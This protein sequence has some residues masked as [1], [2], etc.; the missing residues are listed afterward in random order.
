MRA[1][2]CACS[3]CGRPTGRVVANFHQNGEQ[4]DE[5]IQIEAEEDVQPLRPAHSPETPTAK[6]MEE[7]RYNHIPYRDWCKWCLMGR[8]RGM[9]HRHADSSWIAVV[10][11]DYFYITAGGVKL[12]KELDQT[13][14]DAGNAALEEERKA[15]NIVKCIMVRCTKS[16]NLFAHVVPY[17]GAG[18][19]RFVAELVTRDV[20]WLGHTRLIIKADNEPALRTLVMQ[21]LEE[22]RLK[23]VDIDNISTENPPKYDSQSNGG[24]EVG[25]QLV[26]GIFR[27]LKLCLE[28]RI[29]KFIPIN[30]AVIPWLLEHTC[31]ILNVRPMG[32]DGQTSWSRVRGRA[33]NQRLLG[34]GEVVFYKLPVKGPAHDPDGNMGTRWVE[35]VFLGYHRSSNT[36]IVGNA[37]GI[38]MAR[39]IARRPMPE[40]WSADALV[41]VQATPWSMH[42]SQVRVRFQDP[43]APAEGPPRQEPTPA[44][45]RMRINKTDLETH[46]YTDGC[47]QCTHTRRYGGA[48]PG[49]THTAA[50][51]ARLVEAIGQSAAGQA[52]LGDYEERLTRSMAEHIERQDVTAA[53]APSAPA[54]APAPPAARRGVL[55]GAPASADADNGPRRAPGPEDIRDGPTGCDGPAAPHPTDAGIGPPGDVDMEETGTEA[56]GGD[57]HMGFI[58][59][60]EPARDDFVSELLLSQ[61]GSMGRRYRRE[62]RQ[63]FKKVV[64]EIYSPPRVTKL[65]GESRSKHLVPGLALDLTVVDP[66]DGRPWDF[67][68]RSKR[69]KARQLLR[70]QKPYL[71]IGSPECK[72]FCT[73]FAL[74]EARSTDAQAMRH[75]RTR[76]VAHLEFVVS[77]YVEQLQGGRYFLHEHPQYA[78]SWTERVM[79]ELAEIKGVIRTNGDQCQF[80]A[81]VKHG[82]KTGQPVK[83]PTGFLT[84]S[85]KLAEVLTRRC[86]G[87]QTPWACSRPKGGHHVLCSGRVGREAAIYPRGLCRAVLK[88]I[89]DQLRA[90]RRLKAGCFGVQMVDD[91]EEIAAALQGPEQGFSGKYHDDLTGQI[92]NDE[93]VR[94]ARMC[95][96]EFFHSKGVWVKVP[97]ATARKQTGRPPITVRWVDVNKGDE[98]RPNYRSRLVARQM[99]AQDT[100]GNSYFAPAPPLEALRTVISLAMTEI[101]DHK[102]NHDPASPKR[103]QMSFVDIA[104]AYFNAVVD[105][106]DPPTFVSLPKED[107]DSTSMCARLL[108]HM[109]GTRMAADGWQEEYSTFLIGIGFV[110]GTASPNLLCHHER[111]IA[112]SVHGDD[113]T[114]TGPCDALDWYETAIAQKYEITVGPRIGPGPNDAKEARALNRVIRWCQDSIEYEADPRQA[115]KL[116]AE[117][118]MEGAQTMVTPGVRATGTDLTD[119]QELPPQLTTA[120]R[121]AAARANYLAADRIDAQFACKEI[122]RSMSKPT[123]QSWRALKRVC[124]FLNGVPRLVYTYPRQRVECI[125]VYTDTDWAGCPKTRKSTSGGCVLLGRHAMKHWSSTQASIALSS[126]EAEFGGVVRGAGQGLGYQA[127]LSDL[128]ASVPLR[129]WTDSSAAVGICQRQGLGKLRHLDT[130]TLWVQ[131]AVRTG[132]VD[133]R[134]VLGERNPADLLTKHS[135]SR[136]RLEMLVGLH[137]CRYLEGRAETAPKT[138]KGVSTKVTMASA[139]EDLGAIQSEEEPEMPHLLYD[140]EKLN[141]LY[142]KLEVPDEDLLDDGH[143]RVR[144]QGDHVLA[145]G[146]AIAAKIQADMREVG[147]IRHPQ[148]RLRPE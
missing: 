62:S 125:D 38:K 22:I 35:A 84:N 126:A 127:L 46:G 98:L 15:G 99:R 66:D 50:C 96:L 148:I 123:T 95:E 88:G 7:H 147:R 39:S 32:S 52:R 142:P 4:G 47:P 41:Q 53:A 56:P 120:F 83:K 81:E 63:S 19:D 2:P 132:R 61:L 107:G 40:R 116:V 102:P 59:S 89:S 77:L 108:R 44:I 140:A 122:C 124:R 42:E 138:R 143:E 36:Y 29:D 72:H 119:D 130:Q 3:R 69:E 87:G 11:L 28:S 51:R 9:Q 55:D 144:D 14:D 100:S 139:G 93:M 30:H 68:L 45:R 135:L 137:G 37:D 70:Q 8:G 115:E 73:W 118:G 86:S 133:L 103:T 24:T 6:M 65:L 60:L 76:A 33:F 5:E 10:G 131:Q 75:A 82:P 67:S 113:F 117:C 31:L 23:C 94:K 146:L 111:G 114:A 27:T 112:C 92:L 78:T 134:K 136:A 85:P 106:K 110:Q 104:R 64:S 48:K 57:Q 25:V 13:D 21:S 129:V 90:D 17:K 54:P 16:K 43:V 91:E 101:G 74:N 141:V 121:G 145:H 18:E 79:K 12:R 80:G 34:F 58:G 26:R 109:Y 49:G 97:M 105:E 128:G 1:A 71:L 20:E